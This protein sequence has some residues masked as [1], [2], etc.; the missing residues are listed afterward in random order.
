MASVIFIECTCTYL[1][2]CSRPNGLR[3]PF[4]KLICQ[5]ESSFLN[6]RPKCTKYIMFTPMGAGGWWCDSG[7]YSLRHEIQQYRLRLHHI[8]TIVR[9]CVSNHILPFVHFL[10]HTH[11]VVQTSILPPSCTVTTTIYITHKQRTPQRQ[12]L[13]NVPR[14]NVSV[15]N[16]RH[17]L[18]QQHGISAESL[19]LRLTAHTGGFTG[20]PL[21]TEQ[22]WRSFS[23]CQLNSHRH[24]VQAP[25][26]PA[27]PVPCE[28]YNLCPVPVYC[29][30][31]Q[32]IINPRKQGFVCVCVFVFLQ[33]WGGS[34]T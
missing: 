7:W 30:I 9:R 13:K 4:C 28:N 20:W 5:S 18:R 14:F 1:S 16:V 19:G 10:W 24:L 2:Y 31:I 21:T 32:L 33:Q 27:Q 29:Y 25:C 26:H 17:S 22:M 11:Y 12:C 23:L 34:R 8:Q 3:R 15:C 6:T